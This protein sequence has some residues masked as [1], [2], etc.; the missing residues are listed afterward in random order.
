ML[1]VFYSEAAISAMTGF[2]RAYEEAFYELYRDSGLE[3]EKII[4]E[5]YRLSAKKLSEHIFSEIEQHLGTSKVLGRKERTRWH[6]F[7]F[8]VGS[9][10]ITVY[11]TQNDANG[12]RMVESIGIERKPI[13]F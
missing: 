9:R 11:Y 3:T 5:N 2:I 10:L 12:S 13:I 1:N 6:E 7:S 4:I 8:Y